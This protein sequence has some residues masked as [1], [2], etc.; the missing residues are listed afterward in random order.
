M[1]ASRKTRVLIPI[2]EPIGGQMSA[3]GIRQL[4]VG[5][6]LATHCEVTFAAQK[7]DAANL[8]PGVSVIPCHNRRQFR[9]LLSSH[10]VLFTLGVPWTRFLDVI[11]SR[12]R[13]VL[14]LYTP[15]AFEVMECW[16]EVPGVVMNHLH[17]RLVRWSIAQIA[18]A[19]LVVCTNE[20]QRIL[21][22][23]FMNAAGL[24]NA[25]ESRED[26]GWHRRIVVVPFGVPAQYP[27]AKGRP[28]RNLLPTA[29]E[30]DFVLLW[31]SKILA[32]QDPVTLIR[33]M[34]LVVDHSPD[35]RLVFLGI[36]SPEHGNI[37]LIDNSA[38]RTAQTRQLSDRL[39]LT[40]RNVFF[41]EDR[42]P[43]SEIAAY[44]R[45]ADAAVATF[46]DSL[47]T[48]VCLATR[49]HDYASAGLPMVVSGLQLQRD[50]VEGH[51]LGRV[52]APGD[53]V[54]LASAIVKL[55][56]DVRSGAVGRLT[57]KT[58]AGELAW[59]TVVEPIVHYCNKAD[60]LERVGSRNVIQAYCQLVELVIRS[61]GCRLSMLFHGVR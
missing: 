8:V 18:H 42:I 5:R 55:R 12:I 28:L 43:Y 41:I 32:W 39:G 2:S 60:S 11:Y 22:L 61:I 14:D 48:S 30:D 45:D 17:R 59:S 13:V 20:P 52:V 34:R 15:L 24:L 50:F 49:L 3:V 7:T 35:I 38:L 25:R 10:D 9:R 53:P 40:N 29:G 44:Y 19:D 37:T 58:A 23:G 16:P 33:A 57:A 54:A 47:E 56:D 36:G 26:P 46:P 51:G 21:W 4:E 6:A 31:I 1:N 27:E